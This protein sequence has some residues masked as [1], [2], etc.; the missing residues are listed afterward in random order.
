MATLVELRDT[1][2]QGGVLNKTAAFFIETVSYRKQLRKSP[3]QI[4]IHLFLAFYAF[5]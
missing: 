2:G 1:I 4:L 3:I 5:V